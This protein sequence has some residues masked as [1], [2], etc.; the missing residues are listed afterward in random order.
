MLENGKENIKKIGEG[1]KYIG[2]KLAS[3][4]NN[5]LGVITSGKR[6]KCKKDC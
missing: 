6:R 1:I 2:S 4:L 5:I 3:L